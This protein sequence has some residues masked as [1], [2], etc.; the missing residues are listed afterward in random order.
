LNAPLVDNGGV[1][2]SVINALHAAAADEALP[3]PGQ[4]LY[5]RPV[6]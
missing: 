5:L 3:A 1:D 6:R 4:T 2:S